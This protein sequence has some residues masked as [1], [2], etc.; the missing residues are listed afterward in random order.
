[1]PRP[2]KYTLSED[3]RWYWEALR[4]N[5]RQIRKLGYYTPRERYISLHFWILCFGRTYKGWWYVTLFGWSI[6]FR[7][8]FL[9][10]FSE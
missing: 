7:K 3:T 1:M 2:H 10:S 6:D 5:A 8:P 9:R 4:F